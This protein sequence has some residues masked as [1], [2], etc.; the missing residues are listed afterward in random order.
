MPER[1]ILA[2]WQ[3]NVALLDAY[4]PLLSLAQKEILNL[5]FRF[6]LSLSEIAEQRGSSRTAIADAIKKGVAKLNHYE[7]ALHY[8]EKEEKV[9]SSIEALEKAKTL[10]EAK[11]VLPKLQSTLNEN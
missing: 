11:A 8:L 7:Q 10:D 3:R 2:S 6:N 9:R 1:D 5:Y 4:E